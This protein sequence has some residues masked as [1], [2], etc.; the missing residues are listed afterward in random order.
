MPDKE[1][2]L[3]AKE[4]KKLSEWRQTH[5]PKCST[6]GSAKWI[7][8]IDAVSILAYTNPNKAYPAVCL[9]CSRC[10]SVILISMDIFS[11]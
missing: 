10:K 5:N 3:T 9:F 8:G 1:G 6:C 7:T 11:E 4:K 2:K